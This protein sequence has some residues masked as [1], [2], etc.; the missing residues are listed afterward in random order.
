MMHS[1]PFKSERGRLWRLW[2]IEALP[3]Q[4]T[5]HWRLTRA[6]AVA[7]S[8]LAPSLIAK[9]VNFKGVGPYG[10]MVCSTAE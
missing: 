1:R 7:Y 3:A 9:L 4:L 10:A 8:G 5:R 6:Q 2:A